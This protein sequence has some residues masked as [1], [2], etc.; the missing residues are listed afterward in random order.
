M[1]FVVFILTPR[2]ISQLFV[3]QWNGMKLNGCTI[4]CR[5]SHSKAFPCDLK[6]A[7]YK[8]SQSTRTTN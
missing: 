7:L 3:Q 2:V 1:S 8:S 6:C 4:L 5:D